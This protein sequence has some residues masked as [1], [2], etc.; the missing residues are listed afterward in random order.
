MLLKAG[1]DNTLRAKGYV[2]FVKGSSI[3]R[4]AISTVTLKTFSNSDAACCA[5]AHL[6]SLARSNNGIEQ[7]RVI[8]ELSNF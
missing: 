7:R 8:S 3:R 5:M 6:W 2:I 4:R 1:N